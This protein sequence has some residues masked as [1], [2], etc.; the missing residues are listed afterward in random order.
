MKAKGT[1][2][3]I[4]PVSVAAT[5]CFVL[6][7]TFELMVFGGVFQVKASV[8]R[9]VAPWAYEPFLK[10]T[11]EHPETNPALLQNEAPDETKK[12][13]SASSM[14]TV[15]GFRPEELSIELDT[16]GFETNTVP[17]SGRPTDAGRD[18]EQDAE[19]P[20]PM[21]EIVPVG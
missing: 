16:D 8:V 7:A 12:G 13:V 14:A 6:L 3:R 10:L 17:E 2:R 11:G 15:A 21:E 9:Q 4:V 18:A 5:V 20:V 1:S 19:D